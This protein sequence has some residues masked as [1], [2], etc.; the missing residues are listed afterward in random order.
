MGAFGFV[1]F[2]HITLEELDI[3]Q[4]KPF[5]HEKDESA[6]AQV[7]IQIPLLSGFT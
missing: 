7:I 2:S 5:L 1:P 6:L 3:R 4:C